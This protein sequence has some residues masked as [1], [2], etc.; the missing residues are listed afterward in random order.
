[1][2]CCDEDVLE[3]LEGYL[4][5]PWQQVVRQAVDAIGFLGANASRLCPKLVKLMQEERPEWQAKE[6][7]R[8]WRAQ[9][10]IRFNVVYAAVALLSTPTD[11]NALLAIFKMALLDQGYCAQVAVEGLR[12]IGSKEALALALSYAADRSWDDTLLGSF[13]TF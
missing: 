6:V 9:D 8:G 11:R 12:R 7:T 2:G 13:K 5:S 3:V 1:M 4:D 10:Q